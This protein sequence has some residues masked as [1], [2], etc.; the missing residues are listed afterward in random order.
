MRKTLLAIAIVLCV[1]S[2]PFLVLQVI[3]H[4]KVKPEVILAN[5][6]PVPELELEPELEP[7]PKPKKDEPKK[8]EPS[9]EFL[10]GYWDAQA[11][12]WIGPIK[13]TFHEDYR[14][15]HIMGTH[16][17]KAGLE[18]YPKPNQKPKN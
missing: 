14:L 3:E 4:F 11:G 9:K 2:T 18:R 10:R 8:D 13:W 1:L 17:K 16:D 7:E 6:Q 5:P 12:K 15:G